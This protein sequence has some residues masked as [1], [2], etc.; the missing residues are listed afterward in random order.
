MKLTLL[1][2]LIF[3]M[4]TVAAMAA[5]ELTGVMVTSER[6]AVTLT[7]AATQ[8]HSGWLQLGDAFEGYTLKSYSGKNG[9]LVLANASGSFKL[10]LNQGPIP[11]S[12]IQLQGVIRLTDG[13]KV[14]IEQT[15]LT[16]GETSVFP[17]GANVTCEITPTDQ[18][19]GT[20]LYNMKFQR[21]DPAGGV[22]V[23]DAPQV[24]AGRGKRFGVI[25]GKLSVQFEDR[26]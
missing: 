8:Q 22:T 10:R 12:K 11:A 7:D 19:D 6:T 1:S 20:F 4:T 18:G 13:P 3:G 21:T 9:V 15:T 14:D 2:G 16:I 23:I 24:R 5:P 26:N 25:T 17:L